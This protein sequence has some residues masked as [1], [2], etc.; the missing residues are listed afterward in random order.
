MLS[1]L[2]IK[3]I[4]RRFTLTAQ[5]IDPIVLYIQNLDSFIPLAPAINGTKDL[6]K[7]WNFP[8]TMY[9]NPFFSICLDSI[10]CSV[11]PSQI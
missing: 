5:I 2:S 3:N 11:L 10:F 8:R 1:Y 6:V 4:P 9:Q 7:L